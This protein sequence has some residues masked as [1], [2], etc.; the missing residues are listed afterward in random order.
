VY[1]RDREFNATSGIADTV[2]TAMQLDHL[3][4]LGR[5]WG[6]LKYHHPAVVRGERHFDYDLFR[7]MPHVLAAR[8]RPEALRAIDRWVSALGPIPTCDPCSKVPEDAALLAPLAWLKD[9][10]RLGAGLSRRL[11][12]IY[13]NRPGKGGQFYVDFFPGIGNPDFSNEAPYMPDGFP[14]AGYRLLGLFRLWNM[15]EYWF[16]YRDLMDENWVAV[17]RA[18]LPEFAGATGADAYALAAARVFARIGDG[19]ANL[20][21]SQSVAWPPLT[22]QAPIITRS[23]EGRAFVFGYSHPTL[24]PASG[25]KVGDIIKTV[26]GVSVDS[27]V[28]RCRSRFGVSN[29]DALVHRVLSVLTTGAPGTVRLSITR[30]ERD[31]ELEV[32]RWPAADLNFRLAGRHDHQGAPFKRLSDD[33]AY[34][35]LSSVRAADAISYVEGAA[36]ARCLIIDIR[37]Y[38]SEFMVFALG[39]HLVAEPTPFARFTAGEPSNPGTFVW[40]PSV[41]LQPETPRVE[42][43][44]VVLVDETSVSQSEYTAMAFRAASGALVVG[45]TTAGADGNVSLIPLPGSLRGAMS[46]IGV[47]YPDRR[48]TQRIGIIPDIEVR[49]TIAGLRGGRDEVLEAAVGAVLGRSITPAEYAVLKAP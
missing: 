33:L 19:H 15:V 45:S 36:G 12:N 37:N 7:A 43:R 23:I 40:T 11:G 38:P 2:F 42:A 13:A 20:Y 41:E 26:D 31:L 18:A 22:A 49:P 29:E 5:V 24:G 27:I 17:L 44:V 6:F 10:Q 28:A 4:L 35:T 39:R 9:E 21:A 1:D 3:A 34:L 30:D 48:P 47:F 16:P 25:V 14:D 8:N 32:E 46:G